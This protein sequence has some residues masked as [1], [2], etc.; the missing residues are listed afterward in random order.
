MF[1]I[2]IEQSIYT[3][4]AGN[5]KR[6]E[7]LEKKF[8]HIHHFSRKAIIRLIEEEFEILYENYEIIPNRG[9]FLESIQ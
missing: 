7:K 4:L 5:K 9:L 3:I 2:P 6:L 8:G 1:K